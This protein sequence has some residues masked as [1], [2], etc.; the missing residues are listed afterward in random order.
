[1]DEDVVST[2]DMEDILNFHRTD[3]GKV[4]EMERLAATINYALDKV[5]SSIVRQMKEE[6]LTP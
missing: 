6:D 1:M 5:L 4:S 3:V 2:E